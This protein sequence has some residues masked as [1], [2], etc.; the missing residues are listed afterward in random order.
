MS[1]TF[2]QWIKRQRESRHMTLRRVEAI[3]NGRLSNPYLSQ[4]EGD[5]IAS[6]SVIKLYTLSAAL[7]L[8]FAEVCA[9]ACVGERPPAPQFCPTC[10]QA[11][12]EHVIFRD[13]FVWP[14]TRPLP[15]GDE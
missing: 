4:L 2:G 15:T 1:E 10:G 7:G 9:R 3:S 14:E 5:Q 6:P 11:T 8:D 12:G 13:G